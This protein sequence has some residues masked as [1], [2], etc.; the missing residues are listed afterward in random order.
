MHDRS[1]WERKG[2]G[3]RYLKGRNYKKLVEF[4]RPCKSCGQPFSI[5]VTAPIAEGFKDTN[6]FALVNCEMHRRGSGSKETDTLRAKDAVMT[7][8]LQGM[9]GIERELRS[10]LA[11]MEQKIAAL[12]NKPKKLPWEA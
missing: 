6:S 4:T 8:E 7:E 9:Y 2:E 3:P 12:Q 1:H 10:K 5:F 11:A